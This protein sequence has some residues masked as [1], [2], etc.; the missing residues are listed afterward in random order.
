MRFWLALSAGLVASVSAFPNPKTR[1]PGT[2]LGK[3]QNTERDLSSLVVDL[4]YERYQGVVDGSTGF[5]TWKGHGSV[6][7]QSQTSSD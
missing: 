6:L 3:R 2:A 4:G 7:D 5:K 1:A